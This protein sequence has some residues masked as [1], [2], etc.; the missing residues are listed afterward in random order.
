MLT[1]GSLLLLRC[2]CWRLYPNLVIACAGFQAGNSSPALL[3]ASD[4]WPCRQSNCWPRLEALPGGADID[5][6][7]ACVLPLLDQLAYQLRLLCRCMLGYQRTLVI[8]IAAIVGGGCCSTARLRTPPVD[9]TC[10][11]AMARSALIL[12]G[13][14][15]TVV[16]IPVHSCCCG[17]GAGQYAVG[18]GSCCVSPGS[19][20]T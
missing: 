4:A 8:P 6:S 15:S 16:C 14:I 18:S 19:L 13:C 20:L 5:A 17:P 1:V 11:S 12:R 2:I 9:H 7:Q 10:A 3:C